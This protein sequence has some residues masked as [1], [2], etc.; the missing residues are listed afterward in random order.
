M[1]AIRNK[2]EKLTQSR[3]QGVLHHQQCIDELTSHL[4]SAQV[5]NVIVD[6]SK[7]LQ[8]PTRS[9]TPTSFVTVIEVNENFPSP[10]T[11]SQ[12][13]SITAT[14]ISIAAS[15]D[16]ENIT[17]E[18]APAPTVVAATTTVSNNIQSEANEENQSSIIK[19]DENSVSTVQNVEVKRKIPPR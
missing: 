10:V 9:E 12:P 17:T 11:S 6:D 7:T 1:A 13:S 4:Q 5:K 8:S 15:E 18:S 16:S 2:V 19:C 3:E 14:S